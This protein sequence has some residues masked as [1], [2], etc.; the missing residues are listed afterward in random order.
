MSANFC[1]DSFSSSIA[2]LKP[3]ERN[4]ESALRC[5]QKSPN[6]STFDQSEYPWL[7][8]LLAGMVKDGLIEYAPS[9]YPW[10]KYTITSKGA[11]RLKESK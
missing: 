1:I 11:L 3:R 9:A 7:N 10:T 8:R 2:D 6:V 4:V 5:L